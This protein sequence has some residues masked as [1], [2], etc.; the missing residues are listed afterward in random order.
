M[1]DLI[2]I[3]AHCPTS[4]QVER[5]EKCVDSVIKTGHHILLISHTHIPIHIQKKCQ[6][7]FYDYLNETS[8]DYNLFG[9]SSYRSNDFII[10]SK[11]FQ[12]S[13]YGF[14][15]YRMFSIA[16][17]IAINFGYEKLHHIEYDCE[18][19]DKTIIDENSSLL[20][21]YDSVLYTND[22]T[23]NGFLFGSLKSF[24]VDSLPEFFKT[25]NKDFIENEMKKI[26][27][28]H[29]E[30]LTKKLFINSGNVLFKNDDDLCKRG[31]SKGP[32][33]YAIGV[34]YTLYYNPINNMI[35]IFYLSMK[36][37]EEN[38]VIIVNHDKIV[39]F[40]ALPNQWHIQRLGLLDEVYNVRIDN[41]K[42]CLYEKSFDDEFKKEFINKSYITYYE[43]NN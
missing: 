2:L 10:Q 21:N 8:D 7:Y 16:S 5:L 27:P 19:L 26:E 14:A 42:Q 29:L 43:E 39:R 36:S 1:K 38:I 34:H 22:G 13:F 9:F 31:F 3:T 32:K 41:S 24:K 15:I 12:K 30:F 18:L 4:E 17:Q 40:K 33:F 37:H 6:Y 28:T 11:F 23:P 35:N 20:E 25:Y